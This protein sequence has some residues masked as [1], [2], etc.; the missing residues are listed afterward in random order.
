MPCND[1]VKLFRHCLFTRGCGQPA[2]PIADAIGQ[3]LEVGK[4]LQVLVH[5]CGLHL[6][7]AGEGYWPLPGPLG[8][9]WLGRVAR[10]FGELLEHVL[11]HIECVLK[12]L[13]VVG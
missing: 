8:G 4:A 3:L 6:K 12:R 5:V 10:K 9:N 2:A 13:L 11:A 1:G 7:C